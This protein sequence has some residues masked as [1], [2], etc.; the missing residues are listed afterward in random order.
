MLLAL[1]FLPASD[2]SSPASNGTQVTAGECSFPIREQWQLPDQGGPVSRIALTSNESLCLSFTCDQSPCFVEGK[3]GPS[4]LVLEC[5][6][7]SPSRQPS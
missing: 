1:I 4:A 6:A 2:C 7:D 5:T 3:Y